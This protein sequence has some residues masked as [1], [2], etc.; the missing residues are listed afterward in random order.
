VAP[1]SAGILVY[2][3]GDRGPEFLLVHPGGPYWEKK[4]AGAWSVPKGEYEQGEDPLQVAC[5]ELQEETGLRPVGPFLALTPVTQRGGKVVSAWGVEADFDPGRL[6]SNTF[7]ME[8][9]PRSGLIREFPEVDRAE[10]LTLEQARA[11]LNPAQLPLLEELAAR[12]AGSG[13]A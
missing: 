11:K 9:P 3:R 13:P 10:W 1:R 6:R 2:R 8:W 7:T 4:E 12:L 5:R